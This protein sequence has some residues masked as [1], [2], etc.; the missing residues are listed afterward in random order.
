MSW[1]FPRS[2]GPRE[3]R[4]VPSRP[5]ERLEGRRDDPED[6][7]VAPRGRLDL[8]ASPSSRERGTRDALPARQG[9]FPGLFGPSL[10][11]DAGA[12]DRMRPRWGR[13]ANP[14]ASD[15]CQARES[16][17]MRGRAVSN[18]STRRSGCSA[19]FEPR[20][21]VA[22]RSA[23]SSS[24][25]VCPRPRPRRARAAVAVH[26]VLVDSARRSSRSRAGSTRNSCASARPDSRRPRPRSRGP[27]VGGARAR[28]AA[29]RATG[30]DDFA[31]LL[32]ER[33]NT[34][35]VWSMGLTQHAHGVETIQRARQR[36]PRAGPAGTPEPR[37]D[38]DPR[39]LG[40]PGRRRGR[41]R[42]APVD[43]ETRAAL[44]E[45]R[46]DF[47]SPQPPGWTA[48]EMVDAAA[49]PATID[50]FWIVGGNFLETLAG[51]RRNRARARA[52]AACASTRTSSSLVDARRA[53][54]RRCCCCRPRRATRSPGGGTETS[55]ERRI[56]FSPEIPGRR[57]GSRAAGVGGVRRGHGARVRPATRELVRFEIAAAIRDEIA[58]AVPLYAGIETL[59]RKGDSGAV[60]RRDASTR[61]AA[62]HTPDGQA[63]FAPV[64]LPS[65][66]PRAGTLLRLDAPRQAVQLDG[67]ARASIR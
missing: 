64:G 9:G 25:Q 38:A 54:G 58:R 53:V 67:A 13:P 43:A 23:R 26:Q 18:P 7:H 24:S 1:P 51:D 2:P 66:A 41:L 48:S 32:V 12:P 65:R 8:L 19:V 56:I 59:S 33:P 27:D 63:R 30:C 49:R 46:G 16:S 60:G 14:G 34:H 39:P 4:A 6:V 20:E 57:I 31:Q 44:V 45:R 28:R 10:R 5:G 22:H 17:R 3:R 55:T 61:T 11:P 15:V 37:P 50:V 52:A 29:R 40:R 42:A 62:S 21:V 47:R 35:F 36:R